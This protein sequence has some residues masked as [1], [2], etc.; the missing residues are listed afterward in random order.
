[1]QRC[2]GSARDFLTL[3]IIHTSGQPL[4]QF[5]LARRYE[6]GATGLER[7]LLF[8]IHWYEK[9]ADNS[10]PQALDAAERVKKNRFWRRWCTVAQV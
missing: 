6:L 8:A 4:A 10:H 2:A 5:E 3:P 1:V 7:N 9:A